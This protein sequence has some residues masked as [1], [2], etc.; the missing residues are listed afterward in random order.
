MSRTCTNCLSVVYVV[1]RTAEFAPWRIICAARPA[2]SDAAHEERQ[3][4]KRQEGETHD[5]EE[6]AVH[7]AEAFFAHDA[8]RAVHEAAEARAWRLGVV[9]EL[10]LVKL[11]AREPR[12]HKTGCSSKF[13]SVE[14]HLYPANKLPTW[15]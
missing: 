6:A 11:P 9:D 13:S 7:A 15:R 8:G 10:R 1:K 5:G 12:V 3:T 4:G 14:S 2:V